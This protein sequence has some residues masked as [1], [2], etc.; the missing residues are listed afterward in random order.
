MDTKNKCTYFNTRVNYRSHSVYQINL[1]RN[2]CDH[3]RY[4]VSYMFRH[5]LSAIIRECLYQ[6]KFCSSYK[7][8]KKILFCTVTKHN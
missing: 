4:A 8:V 1:T 7:Y 5:F 2:E 6:L 3:N